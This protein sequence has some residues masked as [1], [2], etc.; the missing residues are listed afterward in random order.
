MVKPFLSIVLPCLNEEKTLKI[1]IEKCH[2]LFSVLNVEGEI[3]VSDNGSTDKSVE[4]AQSMGA[5]VVFCYK[6]G[7]GNTLLTGLRSAQGEYLV[8]CDADNTYDILELK[9]YV[10]AIDENTDMIIGTRLRGYI[11]PGAMPDLHRYFGTP[12]LTAIT[13]ILYGTNISDINCGM[14]LFKKE[15]FDAVNFKSGGMEFATDMIIEFRL[16]NFNI[17]EVP[18]SL[19]KNVQGRKPHLR[20]FRDGFRHLFLILRK[21]IGF[22]N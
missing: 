11:E 3:I 15:S 10:N 8:I 9:N 2:T 13:N 5:K 18:I 7:Y 19:Y 4:I 6:K 22:K 20:P 21:R 16:H 17:K 14:R 12:F 1:C